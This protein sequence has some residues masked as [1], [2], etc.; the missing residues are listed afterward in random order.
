M[1]ED[2]DC[3]FLEVARC[4]VEAAAVGVAHQELE[5]S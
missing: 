1:G 2:L 4:R 5:L 3:C